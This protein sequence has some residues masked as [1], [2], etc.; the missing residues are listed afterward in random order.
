[1][2]KINKIMDLSKI[3]NRVEYINLLDIQLNS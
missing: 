3:K 1:M 2:N